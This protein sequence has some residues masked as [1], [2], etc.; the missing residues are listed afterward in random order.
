MF[1]KLTNQG[2]F[3]YGI[4]VGH[5][6]ALIILIFKVQFILMFCC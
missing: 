1:I 5:E 3:K 4:T 6:N 2:I